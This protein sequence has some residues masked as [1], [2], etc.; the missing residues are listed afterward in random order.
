VPQLARTLRRLVDAE[1]AAKRE[2]RSAALKAA[3]DRFYRGDIA[4]EMAEF[5]EQNGGLFRYED[6]ATYGA[7]VEEPVSIS[8]RGLQVLKDRSANQGPAE[9]F[10]LNI[11]ETHDLQA[12]QH[13]SAEYIHAGVEAIKLAFADREYLGDDRFVN[14]PWETL[15]SKEYAAQR[16]Q[17][18]DPAR[19][20]FEFRE[21]TIP[22]FEHP[23][24]IDD[25]PRSGDGGDTS[26]LC[27]IDQA[28][29]VV[30]FTP[31]LHTGCG[32]SRISPSSRLGVW[33]ASRTRR[34]ARSRMFPSKDSITP[35]HP[36]LRRTLGIRC[37]D[38]LIAGRDQR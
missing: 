31:S 5:S 36:P 34:R 21:G 17:L 1:R 28:R 24:A 12:L 6:F 19:A 25:G 11:L 30:S 33:R 9:L 27:I 10:A 15:R 32:R 14:I 22:S 8:Y 16:R 26:Y 29:N 23:T 37:T 35:R 2:D 13:N 38:D 18:I 4:R 7:I 20:S 3:R